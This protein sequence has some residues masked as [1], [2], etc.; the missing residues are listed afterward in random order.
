MKMPILVSACLLGE[1]VRY[2]AKALPH[3]DVMMLSKQGYELVA[4]CPEVAGGLPVPRAA[5]EICC[6]DSGSQPRVI[7]C[8]G[9]DVT[10]QFEQ[11][12][13]AAFALAKARGITTAVL[14]EGSPSCG[15]C[16]IYDGTFSGNRIAGEG[17]T[18]RLLRMHGIRVL[19][20]LRLD[21]L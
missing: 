2:D 17:I 20:E 16:T 8:M 9:E 10:A 1:S 14:K 19:S 15:S 6:A 18:T 12:A 4:I 3:S 13:A 11:G 21:E 7:S 5:T